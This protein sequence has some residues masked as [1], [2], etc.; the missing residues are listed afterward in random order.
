MIMQNLR[1][2][3]R[4][5]YYGIFLAERVYNFVARAERRSREDRKRTAI[6]AL[7]INLSIG[8][9]SVVA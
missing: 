7:V 3:G 6:Y 5:D 4:K 1:G 9:V 2:R 8:L